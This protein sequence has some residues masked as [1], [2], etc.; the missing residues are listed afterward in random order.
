[1][2]FSPPFNWCDRICERCPLTRECALFKRKEQREWVHRARKED[3]HD[4][5]VVMADVAE[6]IGRSL[7]MLEE[8]AKED[9]IDLDAPPRKAPISLEAVR[10]ERSAKALMKATVHGNPDAFM[11][12]T[13]IVQKSA[14]VAIYVFDKD[15]P[16]L[17]DADAGPNV[18]LLERTRADLGRML[19]DAPGDAITSA[20][21]DFDRAL[22]PL[23]AAVDQQPRGK[24]E[25]LVA[26][27][28]A[29]SPWCVVG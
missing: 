15:E 12:V 4:W 25:A 28:E 11:L 7:A 29:P 23:L 20:L 5:D 8:M 27:G 2:P 24:L 16:D 3:P 9:G 18:L 21:A 14:R 22:T 6:D 19:G 13:R 17:W 26:R 10:L 1:M